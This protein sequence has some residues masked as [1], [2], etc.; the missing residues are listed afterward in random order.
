MDRARTT[1]QPNSGEISMKGFHLDTSAMVIVGFLVFL[2]LG[3]EVEAVI[4]FGVGLLSL[5]QLRQHIAKKM[6]VNQPE[7]DGPRS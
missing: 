7:E 3:R 2:Y 1:I 4:V 5:R 6:Q